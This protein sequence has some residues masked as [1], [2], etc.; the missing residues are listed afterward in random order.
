MN[1]WIQQE[2]QEKKLKKGLLAHW[3]FSFLDL[4]FSRLSRIIVDM[5][6]SGSSLPDTIR[7]GE[8][9]KLKFYT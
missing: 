8:C 7:A 4:M 5:L 9:K 3:D 6:M 1:F 2:V